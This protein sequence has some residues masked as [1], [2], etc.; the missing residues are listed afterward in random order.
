MSAK[1]KFTL[2]NNVTSDNPPYQEGQVIFAFDA[3]K[4]YLDYQVDGKDSR[5]CFTGDVNLESPLMKIDEHQND[6]NSLYYLGEVCEDPTT[7]DELHLVDTHELVIPS[8]YQTISYKH[9]EFIYRKGESGEL[10]WF[11]IGDEDIEGLTWNVFGE[12]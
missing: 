10:N 8:E 3:H 5:N 1:V 11:E 7:S 6:V 2:A 9:K 4:I 12:N